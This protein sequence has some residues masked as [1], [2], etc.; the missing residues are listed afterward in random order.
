M[1]RPA[2]MTCTSGRCAADPGLR[3]CRLGVDDEDHV[4]VVRRV[5][6]NPQGLRQTPT[7]LIPVDADPW[8]VQRELAAP[9][10]RRIPVDGNPRTIGPA[11]AHLHQ[12][13]REMLTKVLA[14]RRRLAENPDDS[15]HRSSFGHDIASATSRPMYDWRRLSPMDESRTL[16]YP[17]SGQ[18]HMPRHTEPELA[19]QGGHVAHS[20]LQTVGHRHIAP[21]AWVALYAQAHW[22]SPA[23][24]AWPPSV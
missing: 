5:F 8:R 24:P 19:A 20:C 13:A 18:L 7:H 3:L 4:I 9:K 16:G 23:R 15:A 14:H 12:H 6:G 11:V 21:A 10:G 2:L 17:T 22:R 1:A